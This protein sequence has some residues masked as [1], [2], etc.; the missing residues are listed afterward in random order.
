MR[1][2]DY[3]SQSSPTDSAEDPETALACEEWHDQQFRNLNVERLEIDEQWSYIHTHKER[4][5][6]TEKGNP[7]KGDSWL[8]AGIDPDSKAILSWRTGLR[9]TEE[10]DDLLYDLAE[11]IDGRVQICTDQL[12]LYYWSVYGAFGHRADYAQEHK[13][14]ETQ[15]VANEQ[16]K[17]RSNR[18]KEMERR[19]VFGKP[20]LDTATCSHI[21][22]FFLTMRQ[23]NKRFARKTL[24]YSK[25]VANH[26]SVN[27]IQIFIYNCCRKSEAHGMAPAVALGILEKEMSFEA[28]AAIADAYS[29]RKA[30]ENSKRLEATK[31][32]E[33][34][35]MFE[36]AFASLASN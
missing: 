33:E 34:D 18:L 32:A 2:G 10:A 26:K 15:A 9:S 16:I 29:Q 23:Q 8:W 13:I 6:A 30:L 7:E 27:S 11:R 24:A 12:H 22:R 25:K 17:M 19:V 35:A 14:F 5:R 20:D 28:I 4:L 31:R 3:R 1:S 21:E 36:A